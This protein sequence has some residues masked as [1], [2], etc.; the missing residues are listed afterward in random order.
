V[1]RRRHFL[2]AAS[3]AAI[4]PRLP[5]APKPALSC[6]FLMLVGGPSQLDTFDMKPDAPSWIRGPFRPIRTNVPGIEI[7]EIF[8]R[9]ARHADKFSLIRAMHHSAAP[10][11]DTGHQLMQTGRLFEQGLEHPHIGCV[12]G[13]LTGSPHALLP[14][15]IGNTGGNM[16]HG[17]S[18]GSLGRAFDP[19]TPS[20]DLSNEPD[21]AKYGLNR[22]G[23]N[24]LAAR[25][26]VESGTR[27]VT[28]NMFDTVFDQL[29]WD[30]HGS[31]PFSPID[32]Y[33][34]TVGPMFDMAYSSLLE[35]LSD[36]GLLSSTM[37]VA[38]GEFG[39]TPRINAAGG[40]DHWPQCWTMLMGG[41]PLKCGEVIGASDKF[42]AEPRD[43]AVT[44]SEIAATIYRGMGIDP[45][46]FINAPAVGELFS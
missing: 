28:V 17:Q 4:A 10:V 46:P 30:I 13:K 20:V 14:C 38:T 44:P 21:R 37:V 26:L 33:R 25:K 6:I 8:P 36:R 40:R 43:R 5:A 7:S 29:T 15:P 3:L 27:F 24:V 9:T 12:V 1:I 16:P 22:F 18:A 42:A 2:H 32:C 45:A 41:G 31:K 35:D 34:H 11:H 19:V 23:Q 39:R